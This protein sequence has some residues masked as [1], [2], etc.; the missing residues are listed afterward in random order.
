MSIQHAH[1]GHYHLVYAAC[2]PGTLEEVVIS[3][4]SFLMAVQTLPT[5]AEQNTYTIHILTGNAGISVE[6]KLADIVCMLYPF[7]YHLP[8]V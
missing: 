8:V 2:G 4:K 5:T 7:Q 1:S 3:I 6:S